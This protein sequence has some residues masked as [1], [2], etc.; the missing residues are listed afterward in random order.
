MAQRDPRAEEVKPEQFIDES[1][2]NELPC[3]KLWGAEKAS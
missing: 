1:F 3:S 2:L